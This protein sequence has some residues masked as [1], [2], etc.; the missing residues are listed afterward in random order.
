VDVIVEVKVEV[1]TMVT[2]MGITME[3]TIM[4]VITMEVTIMEVI[5]IM[6][7]SISPKCSVSAITS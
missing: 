2:I 1:I 6:E 3:V 7:V 5:T 4:E